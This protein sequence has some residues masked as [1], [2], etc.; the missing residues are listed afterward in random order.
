MN[1]TFFLFG[2]LASSLLFAEADPAPGP[3]VLIFKN[4]EKLIGHLHSATGAKVVFV[5]DSAGQVT[6]DWSKI[7]EL[8]SPTRF[9]AVPKGME[10]GG[11]VDKEKVPRGTLE[12]N[13]QKLEVTPSPSAAPQSFPVADVANVMDE[14]DFDHAFESQSLF[15]GWTGQATASAAILEATQKNRAFNTLLTLERKTPSAG[16]RTVR[17]R[18]VINFNSS[19]GHF[20]AVDTEPV[21]TNLYH[22]EMEQDFYLSPR[23]FLLGGATFDHNFAQGLDLMQGYGGGVGVVVAKAERDSLELRFGMGYTHQAWSDSSANRGYLGARAAEYFTHKF[24]NGMAFA[25][26]A[27][28]RPGLSYTQGLMAG[29]TASLAIPVYRR[30][31]MNLTSVDSFVNNPPPGFK[32]NVFQLAFGASY[33]IR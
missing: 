12:V 15:K 9:A 10:L 30:L 18:T 31:S 23:L 27:G 4:G 25:L 5:S 13:D 1:R 22:G 32:K 14:K 2:L 7:Q 11:S 28:V 19:Y 17:R 3:D 29:Y 6:V 26:D 8:R 21:R 33:V 20:K 24:A 16:W